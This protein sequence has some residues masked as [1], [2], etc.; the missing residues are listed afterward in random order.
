MRSGWPQLS[1]WSRYCCSAFLFKSLLRCGNLFPAH[2]PSLCKDSNIIV[3]KTSSIKSSSIS[4][5]CWERIVEACYCV[6]CSERWCFG[7]F[8]WRKWS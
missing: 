2:F 5:S 6:E 7:R 8:R 3:R 4:I 1:S